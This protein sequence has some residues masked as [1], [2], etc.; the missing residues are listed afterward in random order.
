MWVDFF[1]FIQFRLELAFPISMS[2]RYG[3]YFVKSRKLQAVANKKNVV[4]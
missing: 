2:I 4:R 3:D 1:V